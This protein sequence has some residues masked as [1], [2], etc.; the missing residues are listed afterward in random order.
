MQEGLELSHWRP[1]EETLNSV[2]HICVSNTFMTSESSQF[3]NVHGCDRKSED[4]RTA[5]N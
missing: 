5:R 4:F 1:I 3:I 2:A